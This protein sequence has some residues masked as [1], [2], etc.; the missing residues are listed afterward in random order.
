MIIPHIKN[1]AYINFKKSRAP[2]AFRVIG[3]LKITH[4]GGILM[5][6]YSKE[7]NLYFELKDTPES[8]RKSTCNDLRNLANLSKLKTT[9]L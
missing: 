6:D 3:R 4:T 2:P 9:K 1:P 8:S 7:M 5:L